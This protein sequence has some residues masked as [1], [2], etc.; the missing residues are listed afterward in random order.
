M[1]KLT[2]FIAFLFA[3]GANAQNGTKMIGFDAMSMGRA[4]T[5]IG[6]FD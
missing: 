2:L 1:R 6:V 4:G 5:S 3:L